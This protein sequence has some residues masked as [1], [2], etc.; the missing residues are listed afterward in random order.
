MPLTYV[1]AAYAPRH[2]SIYPLFKGAGIAPV[3]R[4]DTANTYEAST[5]AVA[6]AGA[7]AGQ[8]VLR[9]SATTSETGAVRNAAPVE[10]VSGAI[11]TGTGQQTSTDPVETPPAAD[12]REVEKSSVVQEKGAPAGVAPIAEVMVDT[13]ASFGATAATAAAVG[14]DTESDGAPTRTSAFVGG[15]P[16]VERPVA[17][18]VADN[19]PTAKA[20]AMLYRRVCSLGEE[21]LA[22]WVLGGDVK[23]CISPCCVAP[24]SRAYRTLPC[25]RKLASQW[26]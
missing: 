4:P 24:R 11:E 18:A 13:P 3:D 5:A 22:R 8:P 20:S 17:T 19:G 16:E 9:S 2:N 1:H 7:E 15:V 26:S 14:G 25:G 23:S 6:A 12:V 10:Q 21:G